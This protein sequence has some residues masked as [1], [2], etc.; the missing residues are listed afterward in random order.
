[1]S[2]LVAITDLHLGDR[3]PEN[4]SVL[5]SPKVRQTFANVLGELVGW[6]IDTLVITGDLFEV[7][8]PSRTVKQ[9]LLHE[10][11]CFGLYNSTVEDAGAFFAELGKVIDINQ[12]VWVPGNHDFVLYRR[13][14]GNGSLVRPR[15]LR[16]DAIWRQDAEL[17]R[18]FGSEISNI[19]ASFPNY[20]R[21]CSAGWPLAI[22][23]HGHLF[24]NQVLKP[25]AGF[26]K[27]L[28][29]TLE[30]G[31]LWDPIPENIDTD[32][33]SWT[34]KLVELTNHRVFEIWPQNL[35]LV[36]EAVY[37]YVLRR[38]TR[39]FCADRPEKPMVRLIKQAFEKINPS[40][41]LRGRLGWYL[42]NTLVDIAPVVPLGG[43]KLL[44]GSDKPP[45]HSFFVCGHTH[46]PGAWLHESFDGLTFEIYDLG[47]WTMDAAKNR[48]NVPHTHAIVWNHFPGAPYC[49]AL[50]VGKP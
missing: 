27:A 26:L 42:D 36:A 29:L 2:E 48:D 8:V 30:T 31:H 7:C 43:D 45:L 32:G 22:F 41:S 40:S 4:G 13:I 16:E 21:E 34:K 11:T 18:L 1:M 44:L 23:T 6:T 50:N 3:D 12:L 39:V 38:N 5:T 25:T 28:G 17:A 10:T 35:N 37:D 49:Y 19:V 9:D 20:V 24:D 14:C 46:D 33:G 15:K 47:G